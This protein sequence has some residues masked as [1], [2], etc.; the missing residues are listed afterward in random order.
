VDA[1]LFFGFVLVPAIAFAVAYRPILNNLSLALVS[2][3][4]KA[5]L[6]KRFVAA[7]VDVILVTSLLVLYQ[8]SLLFAFIAGAY[9]ALRDMWGRSVGKFCCGLVVVNLETGR[10]CTRGDSI[11]RN[12]LFLLPGANVVA[13][14]LEAATIVTDP[15][16][17][18]LGDR[19]A[20]TQ[21]VE[22]FGVKDLVAAIQHWWRDVIAQL[23]GN[24]R[25]PRRAP[26]RSRKCLPI[27]DAGT[28]ITH[29]ETPS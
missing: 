27:K 21:V 7:S 10:P 19:F 29:E 2:P 24:P 15:Q 3:Y 23:D 17:Q 4:A 9:L 18:R 28:S 22:G 11:N 13:V 14:F 12:A 16:G 8:R 25:K 20:H 6:G 1:R 26:V 5:D